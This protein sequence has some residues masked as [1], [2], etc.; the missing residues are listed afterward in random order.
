MSVFSIT[1]KGPMTFFL[2]GELDIASV[3]S[4]QAALN[5]SIGVGGPITLDLSRLT[6]IDSSG[7]GAIL[8]AAKDHLPGG[9]V[10]LHGVHDGTEKVIELMGVEKTSNIHVLPCVVAA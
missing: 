7:V 10:F 5:G 2:E 6:F 3:P 8:K 4:L 9:C 1:Y